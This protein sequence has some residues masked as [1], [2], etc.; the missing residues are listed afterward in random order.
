MPFFVFKKHDTN[1]NGISDT[2][3]DF[4]GDGLSNLLECRYRTSPYNT[5]TE[6]DGISD[7]DEIYKYRTNPTNP[8]IDGD[9]A[10]DGWEIANSYDPLTFNASFIVT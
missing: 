8:D 7:Y 2:D 3:E 6:G 9:G 1:G 4:D 10:L 5:D